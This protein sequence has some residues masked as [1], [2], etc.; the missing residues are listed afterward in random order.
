MVILLIKSQAVVERQRCEKT[1]ARRARYW[2][3]RAEERTP[4]F[5]EENDAF[6]EGPCFMC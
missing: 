3:A 2:Y 6:R 1:R 4:K 5:R